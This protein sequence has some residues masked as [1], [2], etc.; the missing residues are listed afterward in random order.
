MSSSGATGLCPRRVDIFVRRDVE[1]DTKSLFLLTHYKDSLL[2]S[3]D[4]DSWNVLFVSGREV[5]LL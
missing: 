2:G 5:G 1:F 3:T 4:T